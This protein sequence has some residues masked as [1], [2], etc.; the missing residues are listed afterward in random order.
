[1]LDGACLRPE[2]KFSFNL[3]ISSAFHSNTEPSELAEISA[4]SV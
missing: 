2:L 4:F 3:E 1:M